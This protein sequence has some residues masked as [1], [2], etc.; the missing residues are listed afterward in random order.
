VVRFRGVIDMFVMPLATGLSPEENAMYCPSALIVPR[1]DSPFPAVVT[2]P[3]E[4]D[5]RAT[6]PVSRSQRKRSSRKP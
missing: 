2:D 3:A 1:D 4:C 6:D 5:T